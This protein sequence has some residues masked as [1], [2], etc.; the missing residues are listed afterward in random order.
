MKSMIK[1]KIFILVLLILCFALNVYAVQ[2]SIQE[3]KSLVQT[4]LC[5]DVQEKE[6]VGKTTFFHTRDE[7]VVCWIQFNY[8]S[9]YPFTIT[10]EWLDPKGDKYHTGE[11]GREEGDYLGYRTWYWIGVRDHYAEEL[12]GRWKVN[13]YI[14]DILLATEEFYIE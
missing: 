9:Q 6:P 2:T 1:L 3:S 13:I 5:K 10:W 12:L 7:K 8:S 4:T 11:I 14:D